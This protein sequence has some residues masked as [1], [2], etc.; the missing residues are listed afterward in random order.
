MGRVIQGEVWGMLEPQAREIALYAVASRATGTP[1]EAA[2]QILAGFAALEAGGNPLVVWP[3]SLSLKAKEIALEAELA[4]IRQANKAMADYH[5][6]VNQAGLD[7]DPEYLGIGSPES[8]AGELVQ[9]GEAPPALCEAA[10]QVVF[11]QEPQPGRE[12][13]DASQ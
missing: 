11:R 8:T 4:R 10:A 12:A 9:E 13:S 1:V 6:R 2:K 5:E 3:T 7:R